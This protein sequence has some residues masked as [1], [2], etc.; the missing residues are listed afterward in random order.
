M[1]CRHMTIIKAKLYINIKILPKYP[2][3]KIGIGTHKYPT[4]Y[5]WTWDFYSDTRKYWKIESEYTVL[6]VHWWV[7]SIYRHFNW[8]LCLGVGTR[9]YLILIKIYLC[10]ILN[11]YF[12]SQFMCF[13]ILIILIL[14]FFKVNYSCNCYIIF[15]CK[16]LERKLFVFYTFCII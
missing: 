11:V 12:W 10:S 13:R 3:L 7:P 14:L 9:T 8:L 6:L 4:V 1:V 15:R 5:R 2:N 16:S